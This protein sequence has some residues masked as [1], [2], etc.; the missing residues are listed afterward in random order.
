MARIILTGELCIES[1][2]DIVVQMIDSGG[3]RV[4]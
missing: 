3:F 2:R 1:G 4:D